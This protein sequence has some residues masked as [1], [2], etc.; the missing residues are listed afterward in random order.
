MSDL[1]R[2]RIRSILGEGKLVYHLPERLKYVIW[3][4]M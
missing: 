2:S 3:R 1:L 4:V